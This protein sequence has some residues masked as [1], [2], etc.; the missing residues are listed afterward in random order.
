VTSGRLPEAIS[1][2]GQALRIK[3]DFAEARNNLVRA[4]ALTNQ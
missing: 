2:Y 3:P 4:R 1:H